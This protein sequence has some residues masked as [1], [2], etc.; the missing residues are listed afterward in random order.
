MENSL[1]LGSMS[2]V[3]GFLLSGFYPSR[4]TPVAGILNEDQF[5]VVF[6]KVLPCNSDIDHLEKTTSLSGFIFYFRQ[7]MASFLEV[8]STNISPLKPAGIDSLLFS[9]FRLEISGAG[10]QFRVAFLSVP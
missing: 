6:K 10:L 9:I 4:R 8:N 5:P 7:A 2:Q 1:T 3:S